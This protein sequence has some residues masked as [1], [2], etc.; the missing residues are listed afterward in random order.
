MRYHEIV[1][2]VRVVISSDE[3]KIVNLASKPEGLKKDDLDEYD[4]SL[5][6]SL[7]SKGI[8]HRRKNNGNITFHTSSIKDIWI[9]K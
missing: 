9:D 2:G 1:S 8:L 4:Q 5:A 7:V 3:Q 6:F